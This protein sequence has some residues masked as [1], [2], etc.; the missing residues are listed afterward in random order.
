M[1]KTQSRGCMIITHDPPED[2]YELL[3]KE[4]KLLKRTLRK[5]G[6]CRTLFEAPESTLLQRLKQLLSQ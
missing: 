6:V 2:E 4:N 3:V 5:K 1:K